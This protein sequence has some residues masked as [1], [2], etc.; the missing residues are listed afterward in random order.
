MRVIPGSHLGGGF[1]DNYVATDMSVQTFH[2]EI[3]D[4]DEDQAVDFELARGEFS[5]HDG[6]IVHGAKPNTSAIRR[7]GYTMRYLPATVR[8][9]DV[10]QNRGW[11]I[12]LARGQGA[13]GNS[14]VNA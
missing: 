1:H 2:A 14:Y 13:P 3:P 9:M 8:V 12:W 4:V 10:E 5:M 6:R 11:Q 7:T